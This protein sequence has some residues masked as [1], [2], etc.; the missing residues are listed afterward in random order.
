MLIVVPFMAII[1]C[2]CHRWK[3]AVMISVVTAFTYVYV[4]VSNLLSVLLAKSSM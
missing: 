4:L 1:V 3:V 2:T